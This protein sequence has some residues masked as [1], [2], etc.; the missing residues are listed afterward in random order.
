MLNADAQV[1]LCG[2]LFFLRR[3][4]TIFGHPVASLCGGKIGF[5]GTGRRFARKGCTCMVKW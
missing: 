4:G 1:A 3:R 5:I 2:V